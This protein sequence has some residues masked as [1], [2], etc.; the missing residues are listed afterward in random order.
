MGGAKG[1]LLL[2]GKPMLAHVM[3]RIAPQASALAIN[4]NGDATRFH[5]LG[6]PVIADAIAGFPGPLAGILAG[7]L[8]ARTHHPGAS[9]VLS[10]PCDTPFL[11]QDLVER[12]SGDLAQSRAEIAVARDSETV[13][14]VVGLWPL[15]SAERLADAIHSSVRSVQHWLQANRICQTV[16]A[17]GHFRNINTPAELMAAQSLKRVRFRRSRG[18]GWSPRAT[19]WR[20]P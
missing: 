13:H 9:H 4:G 5:A 18:C 20:A 15:T 17:A 8:W 6:Q 3:E 7:L 1:L 14:P 16:F 19:G 2:D 11:P 10:V 12:L